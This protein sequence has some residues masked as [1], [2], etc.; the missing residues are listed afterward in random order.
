MYYAGVV[1]G[2]PIPYPARVIEVVGRPI[3][4]QCVENPTQEQIDTVH[5]Q[6]LEELVRMFDAHKHRVGWEDRTLQIM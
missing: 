5:A 4:V 3:H 1:F 6:F 2:L